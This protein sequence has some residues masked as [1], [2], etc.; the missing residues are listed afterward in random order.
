MNIM[1]SMVDRG[2]RGDRKVL[3]RHMKSFVCFILSDFS[4]L[5]R[6]ML[7]NNSGHVELDGLNHSHQ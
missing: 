6:D 4:V 3:A 7:F 1:I 2:G 5:Q